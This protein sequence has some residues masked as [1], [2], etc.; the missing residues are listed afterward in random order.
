VKDDGVITDDADRLRA[1]NALLR[2]EFVRLHLEEQELLHI[3]KPNLER[4]HHITIGSWE[5]RIAEADVKVRRLR[6]KI[7]EVRSALRTGRV[8]DLAAMD[9]KLDR[10]FAETFQRIRTLAASIT[11]ARR[12]LENLMNDGDEAEFKSLYQDLVAGL[13]PVLVPGLPDAGRTLWDRVCD[14]Y[15]RHSLRELRALALLARAIPAPEE[16]SDAPRLIH[17]QKGLGDHVETAMRRI[18]G[19]RATPPFTLERLLLDNA[20][21]SHRRDELNAEAAILEAR[22][23]ALEIQLARLM[24]SIG[25]AASF[26][27]N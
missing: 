26:G 14:A 3:V 21:V 12:N 11:S 17:M 2:E 9:E 6:R 7:E 25:Q 13:H 20:W 15:A 5:L 8:V 18:A 1:E 27:P 24:P 19:L 16:V 23:D 10:E 22:A 4:L